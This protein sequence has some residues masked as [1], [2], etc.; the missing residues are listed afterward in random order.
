MSPGSRFDRRGVGHVEAQGLRRD[1]RRRSARRRTPS[2]CRPRR[3]NDAWR[4]ASA[5]CAAMARPMPRDAPVTSATFPGEIE[6]VSGARA[7]RRASGERRLDGC[8]IVRAAEVHD[9][10]FAMNPAD[11]PAQHRAW[12]HLNIRCD[13]FRRKASA[14]PPPTAPATKPA[15]TSASIAL[16]AS[17]FGSASTLATIGTRGVC[18]PQRAQLRRQAI[19]G[20]FHQRAVE[21]RAHRQRDR[22]ALRRAPSRVRRRARR[23]SRAPAITTCPPPFMFAGLTTSPLAASAHACATLSASRPEDRRHRAFA[24]RHRLLHVAPAA[25]HQ[26]QRVGERKRARGDVGRVFAEAV[27]CDE[28]RREARATASRRYA[29]M[30]TARIA[31]C[32]FS[33][34]VS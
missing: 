33:V 4:P 19:F 26:P 24:D 28:R 5:S 29:A 30:L 13:A 18:D 27:A 23:P 11:Q 15:R 21:R 32:V 6:H 16:L 1:A 10:G 31:G 8:Q 25:P 34:S 9:R 14:R 12:T 3:G 20:R 2:R 7:F 17:R 22:P